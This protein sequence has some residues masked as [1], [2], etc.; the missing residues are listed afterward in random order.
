MQS[1]RWFL[2]SPKPEVA[3]PCGIEVDEQ[4]LLARG[5]PGDAARLTEVVLFPT[6]PF[7]LTTAKDARGPVRR[8]RFT[9]R[10]MPP[11]PRNSPQ[12]SIDDAAGRGRA[13][14]GQ[15]PLLRQARAARQAIRGDRLRADDDHGPSRHRAPAHEQLMASPR[16][17]PQI[18]R[19]RIARS[20]F[21]AL[22]R[23]P[24]ARPARRRRPE[25]ERASSTSDGNGATA[26]AAAAAKAPRP[27]SW[28]ALLGALG[29]DH[30][31][32]PQPFA[33]RRSGTP[34]SSSRTPPGDVSARRRPPA[35]PR[36]SRRRT[37]CRR[38]APPARPPPAAK[39]D[40]ESR[41]ESRG[42]SPAS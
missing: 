27:R 42:T 30:G 5:R 34:P 11:S 16:S 31:V 24:S 33:R 29:R 37:R 28:A 25:A 10:S 21:L 39:A 41:R 22:R 13:V 8:R 1:S 2:L 3:L 6:P 19:G 14:S 12:G 40:S 26:R 18:G 17:M 23:S 32:Q 36:D 35:A 7:W 4:D 9:S 38:T 20:Q 15:G